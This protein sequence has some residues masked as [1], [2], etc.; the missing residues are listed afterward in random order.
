V[1]VVSHL[2]GGALS[3]DTYR[4]DAGPADVPFPE[5]HRSYSLSYVHRGTFGYSCRGERHELVPGAILVGR[6]GDEFTCT[7]DHREGGDECLSF[8]LGAESVDALGAAAWN[9]RTVPPLAR[10]AVLAELALAVAKGRAEADLDE[11]GLALA[12]RFV[13]VVT[14]RHRRVSA[15]PRDRR[16][17]VEAALW[18]EANAGE[19]VGLE[20]AARRAGLSSFHF[21]RIF[22]SVVGTTPHQFVVRA[23]LRRA[24]RLLSEPEPPVGE[25]ALAAGFGDLS[26]FVRT[27]HRAAG[28][29]PRAFRRLSRR[30]RKI[31]QDRLAVRP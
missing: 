25:V 9:V 28:I 30:D 4:C 8:R 5:V 15:S 16:R 10:I 11:L 2:S 3:V 22:S 29:S 23:R 21:L 18:L 27:F 31:L 7:H 19:D 12:A 20:A 13:E 17:A 26:N 1:R 14:G 6:P 24:A